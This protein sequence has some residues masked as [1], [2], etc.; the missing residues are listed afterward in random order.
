MF[1][2]QKYR[3]VRRKYICEDAFPEVYDKV[4]KYSCIVQRIPS[5]IVCLIAGEQ[6]VKVSFSYIL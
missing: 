2:H 5:D 6:S 3:A 1:D 4:S